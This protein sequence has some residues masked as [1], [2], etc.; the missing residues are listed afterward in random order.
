MIKAIELYSKFNI[1]ITNILDLKN[2]KEF[3]YIDIELIKLVKIKY[4]LILYRT[5][6]KPDTGLLLLA[7][8]HSLFTN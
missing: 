3:V 2:G 5:Y 1:N 7:I 6:P 4:I 8:V